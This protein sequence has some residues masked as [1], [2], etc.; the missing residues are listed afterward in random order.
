MRIQT[1]IETANY[2][3]DLQATEA[4]YGAILGLLLGRAAVS[5]GQGPAVD[6]P[7]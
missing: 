1:I 6:Q 2:V 5:R 7:G 3:H 4:F